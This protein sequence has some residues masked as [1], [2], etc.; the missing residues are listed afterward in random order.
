VYNHWRAADD[1]RPLFQPVGS[2]MTISM[3]QAS[4]ILNCTVL[5]L[6]GCGSATLSVDANGGEQG[7]VVLRGADATNEALAKLAAR[8]N[9]THITLIDAQVTPEGMVHLEKLPRLQSYTHLGGPPFISD[10]HLK[11]LARVSALRNLTIKAQ[12]I[13]PDGIEHL[14]KLTTIRELTMTVLLL[15]TNDLAPLAELPNLEVLD[16]GKYSYVGDEDMRRLEDL[17]P[18][19][20]IRINND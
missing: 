6:V 8:K 19:V 1:R 9:L 4:L 17:F 18:N 11:E 13:T 5:T 7:K 20:E 10:D 16:L 3:I 2:T 12:E 14:K 15:R